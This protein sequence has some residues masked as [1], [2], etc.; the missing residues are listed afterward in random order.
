MTKTEKALTK[1]IAHLNKLLHRDFGTRF[2]VKLD[3]Y[4]GKDEV[5]VVEYTARDLVCG[6]SQDYKTGFYYFDKTCIGGGILEGVKDFVR[7]CLDKD[8]Y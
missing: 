1:Y 8:R 2:E 5:L 3:K 7:K 6:A 4:T